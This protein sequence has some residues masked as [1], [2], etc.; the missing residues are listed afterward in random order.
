M[1]GKT[2]KTDHVHWHTWMCGRVQ[3]NHKW[4]HNRLQTWIVER[5]SAQHQ[6]ILATFLRFR[7]L[8]YSCTEGICH[9]ST[10]PGTSYH[11]TLLF[12]QASPHIS[13]AYNNCWG[14]KA[15]VRG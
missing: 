2:W 15:G 8:L 5:M 13:T 4:V 7:K 14:E 3:K 6:T 11:M 9:S 10:R 12:Y 1:Q